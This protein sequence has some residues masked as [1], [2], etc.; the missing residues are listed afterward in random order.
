MPLA[1]GGSGCVDGGVRSRRSIPDPPLP[2]SGRLSVVEAQKP[3]EPLSAADRSGR[4]IG[5]R[6]EEPTLKALVVALGVVVGDV[7]SDGCAEVVLAQEHELA[8]ALALDGAH[9]AF[10]VGVQVGAARR[11]ADKHD[12]GIA[13]KERALQAESSVES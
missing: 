9:E 3:A 11:Q 13:Q 5:W 1:G 10:S 4:V 7:F 12:P 6:L 8:E 2:R